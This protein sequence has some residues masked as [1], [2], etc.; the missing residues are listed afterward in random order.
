MSEFDF[1][2]S[3]SSKLY[4]TVIKNLMDACDEPLY[5]GD[6]RRIF[7]E[8]IVFVLTSVF[9]LFNDKAK[10]RTLRFARGKVL[11]AIGERLQVFRAEPSKASA[12]FRFSVSAV[13]SQNIIIPAGTRITADGTVYFVTQDATTLPAGESYVDILAVCTEGGVAYNGYAAG[14]IATLVDLIPYVSIVYNIDE[15]AGGDDGEPYTEAGDDR[16]R[17]R[18]RMA[19]ASLSPGTEAGYRYHAMSADP[20]I[21]SVAIDCPEGDPNTVNIYPLMNGGELPDEATLQKVLD[22]I[23][24]SNIRIMTDRV[25][26]L[27][28]TPVDYT[29]EIKYYCTA[30][31]EA[32][33]I[34][35]IEGSGGA[36]EQYIRWQSAALG[37]DISP[38]KL[39]MFLF[40]PAS[41]VG[42]IRADI[43]SPTLEVLNN[44]QVARLSG[45]PVVSHEVI[46]E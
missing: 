2:E 28:P 8:S 41:G 18:I 14:S 7:G 24:N 17:E 12:T 25:Q 11:D 37:R 35:A 26:A 23:N 30:E 36:I 44:I 20:D 33:T 3:D 29:M 39:R 45:S 46:T 22:A 15:T 4:T 5:P 43:I 21:A 1:V 40:A 9:S 10:Q 27:A 31:N 42:A 6:E 19:P 16:F 34:E 32:A 13:Q 38:D